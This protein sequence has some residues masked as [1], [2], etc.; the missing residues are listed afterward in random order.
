MAEYFYWTR[1]PLVR[2]PEKADAGPGARRYNRAQS[3][4]ALQIQV[5]EWI[6]TINPE[7]AAGQA[8]LD[9][10]DD[11]VRLIQ[12]FISTKEGWNAGEQRKANNFLHQC[13][14]RARDELGWR[15]NPPPRVMP[16]PK[17]ANPF[18]LSAVTAVYDFQVELE[19]FQKTLFKDWDP[20][21]GDKALLRRWGRLLYS[22]VA[23]GGLL[24]RYALVSLTQSIN[25]VQRYGGEVWI[26]LFDVKD[27]TQGKRV[28]RRWYP[29]PVSL[30]LIS[31]FQVSPQFQK[32]DEAIHWCFKALAAFRGSMGFSGAIYEA[33]KW[34]GRACTWMAMSLPAYLVRYA[35]GEQ[36]STSF[37]PEVWLRILHGK[38]VPVIVDTNDS[39]PIESNPNDY[40]VIERA[41]SLKNRSLKTKPGHGDIRRA[42]QKFYQALTR[43]KDVAGKSESELVRGEVITRIVEAENEVGPC[44][45]VLE[46][47]VAWIKKKLKDK[48][49]VRSSAAQYFS[50]IGRELVDRL[51]KEDLRNLSE[52]E[53]EAVYGEII[54]GADKTATKQAKAMQLQQFHQFMTVTYG[55]VP[56]Q[57]QF[58]EEL[59]FVVDAD[60]G[61]LTEAEYQLVL[62][63]L[64]MA[65]VNVKSEI[66][67]IAFVL[68]YRCGCRINECAHI[69]LDDLQYVGMNDQGS[70]PAGL[71]DL[72]PMALLLRGN[73]YNRLKTTDSRRSLP[74]YLFLNT[75]EQR[76]LMEFHRKQCLKVGH[77]IEGRFL[78]STLPDLHSPIGLKLIYDL[79]HPVM[80]EIT[81]NPDIRFHHLRHSFA[82]HL[83]AAM[84][85]HEPP[86]PLP[87][88]WM[89]TDGDRGVIQALLPSKGHPS[90]LA[91]FQIADWL[92]HVSPQMTLCQYVHVCDWM[93]REELAAL[94]FDDVRVGLA[95]EKRFVQH[96]DLQQ[97]VTGLSGGSAGGYRVKKTRY[98]SVISWIA[99]RLKIPDQAK[100]LGA[101]ATPV[102]H[103]AL[104]RDPRLR[105][106]SQLSFD[107]WMTTWRMLKNK[108]L[109]RHIESIYYM[110]PGCTRRITKVLRSVFWRRGQ[111][112]GYTAVHKPKTS[113]GTGQ[114]TQKYF[115]D[116][117]FIFPWVRS[118]AEYSL[119]KATYEK[120]MAKF[121]NDPDRVQRT[122]RYF[123]E[124]Y[125]VEDGHILLN[126]DATA[127]EMQKLIAEIIPQGLS[128]NVKNLTRKKPGVKACLGKMI[129]GVVDKTT[130]QEVR[131]SNGFYAGMMQFV[132]YLEL[133]R[134]KI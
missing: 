84:S 42:Y 127:N 52:E 59:G 121:K 35:C 53:F 134:R 103:E 8:D 29:D 73:A 106:P 102:I 132:F 88:H 5:L 100:A 89:V 26:D 76:L 72:P 30:L 34:H 9:F 60:A 13:L 44:G 47:L 28:L 58:S 24:D 116:H 91:L 75:D 23:L 36:R 110:Q 67:M 92:G 18:T 129:V 94:S 65:A 17:P 45:M 31:E 118:H 68:G 10:L 43:Q 113:R 71:Q 82:N 37:K 99:A 130:K 115:D 80:R 55:V 77:K 95:W 109:L 108:V 49:L 54:D 85:G 21:T 51:G 40:A 90:R 83:M 97:A 48:Q 125:R 104:H 101:Y 78:F 70:E 46:A 20:G 62:N 98:G 87:S 124:N 86:S 27:V 69:K 25:K 112:G 39:T 50:S 38:P 6:A 61:F 32:L 1:W 133:L 128:C 79:V 93:L 11:H 41:A 66:V 22:A 74:L 19:V 105:M 57:F 126:Q 111:R 107:E 56:L 63:R 15:V 114:A 14:K 117:G 2:L 64:K 4:R 131:A 120:L 123:H 96:F 7:A 3:W 12:D 122:L 119:A 33:R 81:G 16:L